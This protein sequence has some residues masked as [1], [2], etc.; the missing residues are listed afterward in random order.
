VTP[1]Q[2]DRF[3]NRRENVDLSLR[4][5]TFGGFRREFPPRRR[6]FVLKGQTLEF[7]RVISIGSEIYK[8]GKGKLVQFEA[9][10][11]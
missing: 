9:D 7:V 4:S 3:L 11:R 2:L 6:E 10:R 5:E 8:T 1:D